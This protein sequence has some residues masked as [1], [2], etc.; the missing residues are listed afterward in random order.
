MRSHR[1]H[2]SSLG[3][4]I[5]V[6]LG[7]GTAQAKAGIG[8]PPLSI[9]GIIDTGATTTAIS[10]GVFQTLQPMSCGAVPLNRPGG[11]QGVVPS[12]AVRLKFEGHLAPNPWFDVDVVVANPVTPGIDVLVGMDVLSQIVLFFEGGNGTMIV[13][14]C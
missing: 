11:G 9:A 14:Y 8:G 3:P 7:V 10:N 5:Q 6:G 2:V 12:Y 13:A 1:I 4:I